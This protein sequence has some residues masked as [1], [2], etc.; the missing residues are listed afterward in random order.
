MERN[1]HK[2]LSPYWIKREREIEESLKDVNRFWENKFVGHA[3]IVEGGYVGG[4][5][6]QGEHLKRWQES[7]GKYLK[8]AGKVVEVGGGYG[9]MCYVVKGLL[10]YKRYTIL[11]LPVMN[12]IQRKFLSI[13]FDCQTVC[14]VA[15]LG[16]D[17]YCR[18]QDGDVP[19]DT[20]ISCFALSETN[21]AF[22]DYIF[23][24]NFLDAKNIIVCYN[25][26]HSSIYDFAKREDELGKFG[27][28][29]HHG[30]TGYLFK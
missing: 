3:A 25:A 24:K 19:C 21:D 23:E 10:T 13:P 15:F 14:T 9:A 11:D 29:V 7:T 22:V 30:Q 1:Y 6:V 2:Y 5:C 17:E 20:F 18:R 27:K 26:A 28:V 16:M 4:I 8:D 12:K